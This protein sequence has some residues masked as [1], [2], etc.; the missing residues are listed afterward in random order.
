M[1]SS[2]ST[3]LLFIQL[4]YCQKILVIFALALIESCQ[5]HIGQV[6]P[7]TAI[8]LVQGSIVYESVLL[9]LVF[10]A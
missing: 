6:V 8:T 10:D 2:A 3:F 4:F 5:R 9:E 7:P 1:S